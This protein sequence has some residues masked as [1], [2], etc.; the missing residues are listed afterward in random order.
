MPLRVPRG[1]SS[2]GSSTELEEVKSLRILGVI[3]DSFAGSC[4][5]AS[6][7]SGICAPSRKVI[8]LSTCAQGLF[9]CMC[10]T[11]F[12]VLCPRMDVA[13]GIS[14]LNGIVRHVEMLNKSKF[15]CLGYRRKVSALC[16]LYKIYHRV[17]HTMKQYP[18]PFVVARNTRASAALGEF[19]L[20]IS[21]CITNQFI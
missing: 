2:L 10:F 16:L 7:E 15:C 1:E 8:R 9:Q 6:Q 14:L 4:V 12:E 13:G 20:I 18:K 3:L 11:Q 19:A 21:R 17:H 5:R